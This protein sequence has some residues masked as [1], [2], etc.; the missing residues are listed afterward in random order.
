MSVQVVE[1]RRVVERVSDRVFAERDF[2]VST[3]LNN[4]AIGPAM[5]R[6]DCV[7]LGV[8]VGMARR[9]RVL[10]LEILTTPIIARAD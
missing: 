1:V 7:Q 10:L 6:A 4:V 9:S 8:K 5:T 2:D 3:D